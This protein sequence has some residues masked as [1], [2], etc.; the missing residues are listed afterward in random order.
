MTFLFTEVSTSSPDEVRRNRLLTTPKSKLMSGHSTPIRNKIKTDSS[1]S[2]ELVY[3]ESPIEPLTQNPPNEVGWDYQRPI[4]KED[5]VKI[6]DSID[7]SRTPKRNHLLSKKRN[8][9]SPL[10]YKPLKKKL[11]QEEQKQ[12]IAGF[13]AELK[14]IEINAKKIGEQNTDPQKTDTEQE[15]QLIVEMDSQP[16]DESDI[17]LQVSANTDESP[18]QS[19]IAVTNKNYEA[20][21][22][23]SIEEVMVMCSQEVEAKE[24]EMQKAQNII[25]PQQYSSNSSREKSSSRTSLNSSSEK[26]PSNKSK[27]NVQPSNGNIFNDM[28]SKSSSSSKAESGSLEIPDDSLDELFVEIDDK[29]FMK[30]ANTETHINSV[31]KTVKSSNKSYT[32]SSSTAVTSGTTSKSSATQNKFFQSKGIVSAQPQS[33]SVSIQNKIVNTKANYGYLNKNYVTGSSN[34]KISLKSENTHNNYKNNETRLFKAKSFSDSS[35]LHQ[36]SGSNNLGHRSHSNLNM[37]SGIQQKP[38]YQNSVFQNSGSSYSCNSGSENKT[39]RRVQSSLS[40]SKSN[41]STQSTQQS[42]KLNSRGGSQLFTPAEIERKRQE[43][44]MKREAKLKLQLTNQ[45]I[46]RPMHNSVKR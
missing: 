3:N 42:T 6:T 13:M 39:W 37:N 30:S 10:L 44:M 15:S 2:P 20:L 25:P 14:A 31:N 34:S 5:D 18:G 12:V 24:F 46:K 28:S 1:D 33:S 41:E 36:S 26:V 17:K 35:F 29:D 23:D 43:A 9:N 16:S 11:I 38:Q 27:E 7:I 32:K 22:D 40:I 21:L 4:G 8:S 45:Q 19:K